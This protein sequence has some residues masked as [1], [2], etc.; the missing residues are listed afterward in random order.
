M[1]LNEN[2]QVSC[3]PE[4][5]S[6]PFGSNDTAIAVGWGLLN[7]YDDF[8]PM[9]MNNVKLFV[10]N[11][12]MCENVTVVDFSVTTQLCAGKYFCEMF[13]TLIYFWSKKLNKKT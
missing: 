3:L 4:T 11:E 13:T 8:P 6:F 1:T 10:Y 2:V 9:K 7:E 5:K 12:T